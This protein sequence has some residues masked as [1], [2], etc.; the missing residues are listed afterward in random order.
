VSCERVRDSKG[1]SSTTS[2]ISFR[3]TPGHGLLRQ[4][5][6]Q[7]PEWGVSL[8]HLAWAPVGPQEEQDGCDA[9]GSNQ[10]HA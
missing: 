4:D 9:L 6:L 10:A 2:A 5:D 8:E 7:L 1:A 3:G